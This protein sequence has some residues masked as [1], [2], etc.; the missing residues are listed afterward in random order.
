LIIE[1]D[2]AYR[3]VTSNGDDIGSST[4]TSFATILVLQL[5]VVAKLCVEERPQ[6]LQIGKIGYYSSIF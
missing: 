6:L 2:S 4:A 3:I 1:E 5:D